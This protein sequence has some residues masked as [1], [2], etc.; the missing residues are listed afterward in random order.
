ME[1]PHWGHNVWPFVI[2]THTR[3][4]S[5]GAPS[6]LCFVNQVEC[7]PQSKPSSYSIQYYKEADNEKQVYSWLN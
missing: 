2:Y 5:G 4:G 1:E 3:L 6:H 7:F